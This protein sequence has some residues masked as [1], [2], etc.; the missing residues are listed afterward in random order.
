MTGDVFQISNGILI[1]DNLKLEEVQNQLKITTF[2]IEGSITD[3]SA[4]L[5]KFSKN[6]K[7]FLIDDTQILLNDLGNLLKL[8]DATA[9]LT[10]PNGQ[11]LLDSGQTVLKFLDKKLLLNRDKLRFEFTP[12]NYLD[13]SDSAGLLYAYNGALLALNRGI[14][15]FSDPFH[16]ILNL[17]SPDDISWFRHNAAAGWN[18]SDNWAIFTRNR[19][20]NQGLVFLDGSSFLAHD[21][22][23]YLFFQTEEV[24]GN[25]VTKRGVFR[26]NESGPYLE[27]ETVDEAQY[28][29]ISLVQADDQG[30]LIF[31]ENVILQRDTN[32]YLKFC[33]DGSVILTAGTKPLQLFGSIVN[34]PPGVPLNGFFLENLGFRI[35]DSSGGFLDINFP[36]SVSSDGMLTGFTEVIKLLAG[37]NI[38]IK[39]FDDGANAYIQ[40]DVIQFTGIQGFT[41]AQGG[42][43]LAGGTG[44]QG[45]TGPFGGPQGITGFQ[46]VTGIIGI[47]GG[48]GTQGFT[49]VQ[50]VVG[51]IGPVGETGA[52]G[53]TG[54]SFKGPTGLRGPT[55]PRGQTGIAGQGLTGISGVTG[56]QGQTGI[57]GIPGVAASQGATGIQGIPG[58]TGATGISGLTGIQGITGIG[59]PD[60]TTSGLFRFAASGA[61]ISNAQFI[62]SGGGVEIPGKLNVG[63]LIDPTG[64][65]LVQQGTNPGDANTI[66]IN[67]SGFI[68][69]GSSSIQLATFDAIVPDNFATPGAAVLASATNIYVRNG[70]YTDSGTTII[71]TANVT[72]TGQSKAG[73]VWAFNLINVEASGFN[74]Q[75]ITLDGDATNNCRI[76][77]DS[78][79]SPN[80][81]TFQDLIHR[82]FSNSNFDV[83][84][85]A[86]NGHRWSRIKYE[87]DPT[88]SGNPSI[89]GVDVSGQ[90]DYVIED[91]ILDGLS[92]ASSMPSS[93]KFMDING[94]GFDGIRVSRIKFVGTPGASFTFWSHTSTGDI[95][96]CLIEDVDTINS[97]KTGTFFITHINW[98]GNIMNDW[99]IQRCKSGC[100]RFYQVS[101]TG[102]TSFTARRLKLLNCYVSGSV[103]NTIFFTIT[104]STALVTVE[105]I[106][107]AGCRLENG[108]SLAAFEGDSRQIHIHNCQ[109]SEITGTI[110]T[111]N[112]DYRDILIHNMSLETTT[113]N[114]DTEM[115]FIGNANST[116]SGTKITIHSINADLKYSVTGKTA[117]VRSN[118]G[119]TNDIIG[120]LVHSINLR[121]DPSSS[122]VP[123]YLAQLTHTASNSIQNVIFNNWTVE[124][125]PSLPQQ[126]VDSAFHGAGTAPASNQGGL[127]QLSMIKISDTSRWVSTDNATYYVK[128]FLG[129]G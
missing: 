77:L 91:F 93:M 102:S 2:G 4:T 95:S 83:F 18:F 114:Y 17:K 101:S 45:V 46:G 125:S 79:V 92:E 34:L 100:A 104:T 28:N 59:G 31:D 38:E 121:I 112:R 15:F 89:F 86:G 21:L 6:S 50:G 116:A 32:S 106:E 1:G 85:T 43:G 115:F 29:F 57:Q 61:L 82:P 27:L 105:N 109:C 119:T 84:Q 10:I 80:N 71:S 25:P 23:T 30:K 60:F 40:F 67:T 47:Q 76:V 128:T 78:T 58:T 103:G 53:P 113:N 129:V 48:T 26:V 55:G 117:V 118:I 63:G 70:S 96:N 16:K 24:V 12:S 97:P 107:I 127:A 51:P 94:G 41:G 88:M 14:E 5:I 19:F 122:F 111:I 13:I 37:D 52:V 69:F 33:E 81:C 123:R 73:V 8:T 62:I 64:L 54:A 99:I 7:E 90:R 98:D 56:A 124:V 9:E 75:N 42:T 72:I 65:Q 87:L 20:L 3:S 74:L 68:Q 120:L 110:C 108:L 22:N 44:L 49:G 36:K 35:Y 66:W 39:G 126:T 11:L